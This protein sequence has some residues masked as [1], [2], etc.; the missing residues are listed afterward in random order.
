MGFGLRS[1]GTVVAA[2]GSVGTYALRDCEPSDAYRYQT[3]LCSSRTWDAG[4]EIGRVSRWGSFELELGLR[5]EY[6]SLEVERDFQLDPTVFY[7]EKGFR[8]GL[9]AVPEYGLSRHFAIGASLGW[10]TQAIARVGARA[11]ARF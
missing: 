9:V 8:F 4:L 11:E 2:I 7:V 6:F 5:A 1:E 10:D 3:V